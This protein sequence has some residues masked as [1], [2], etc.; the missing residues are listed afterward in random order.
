MRHDRP[1]PAPDAQR[2]AP[3][4][5]PAHHAGD[6]QSASAQA[7]GSDEGVRTP[8]EYTETPGSHRRPDGAATDV[9]A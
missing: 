9:G 5:T 7:E 4:P 8:D 2:P 1:D 6:D 3:T